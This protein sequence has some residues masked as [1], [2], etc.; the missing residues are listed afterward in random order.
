MDLSKLSQNA[1]EVVD[2]T[3]A[4]GRHVWSNALGTEHLLL[5]LLTQQDS[6]V[7]KVFAELSLDLGLAQ[8][9]SNDAIE[10]A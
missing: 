10:K 5:G 7:N 2:V 1:R 9:K 8:T 6:V 4:V 3:Q